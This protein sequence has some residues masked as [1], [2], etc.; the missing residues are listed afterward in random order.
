MRQRSI[1]AVGIVILGLVPALIGGAIFA[2]SFG[3]IAIVGFRELIR[4]QRL[5]ER[6]FQMVGYI[7]I[8]GAAILTWMFPD[9]RF[10]PL[11]LAF[12]VLTNLSI[13]V[14]RAQT[15]SS[16][17]DWN[18]ATGATLYIV[19]PVFAAVAMR[20]THGFVD[21]QWFQSLSDAMPGTNNTAE[22]LGWFLTALFIT[23]L[24]DTAAYLVGKSVGSRKLI[25]HVS[26]N[27]TVEGAIG[28]LLAAGITSVLC[29]MGFG[30]SVHP[31]TA[32]LAGIFLGAIG[33]FGDLSVSMIKRR[34][35]AKDS[36]H[37]IPGHGGILDRIDALI[38]V[39]VTMWAILP[40]LT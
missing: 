26:P 29:M 2:V 23:W 7:S 16:R 39:L 17:R 14:F 10:F 33:I 3:I 31:L 38:F 12:I 36:G 21:R 28:G 5:D 20:E 4:L 27:K 1:S 22:G 13:I 8:V 40:F 25:P 34:A 15:A 24:S 6:P 9:G 11:L 37:L 35:R 32:F 19:L 30:L 18:A